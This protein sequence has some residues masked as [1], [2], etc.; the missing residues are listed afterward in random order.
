MAI[1]HLISDVHPSNCR[2]IGGNLRFV[3]IREFTYAAI[4]QKFELILKRV[5]VFKVKFDLLIC[6]LKERLHR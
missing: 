2:S 5:I 6:D 1:S 3:I 4:K